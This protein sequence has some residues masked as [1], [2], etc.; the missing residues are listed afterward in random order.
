MVAVH[1]SV[2]SNAM[3]NTKVQI[4]K[5]LKYQLKIQ[6]NMVNKENVVVKK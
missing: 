2:N 1:V 6:V 4:R 3:K 5:Y